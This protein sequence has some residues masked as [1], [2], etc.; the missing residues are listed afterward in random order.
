MR[1]SR[2]SASDLGGLRRSPTV[3]R[4]SDRLLLKTGTTEYRPALVGTEWDGG[5]CAAFGANGAGFGACTRGAGGSLGLALL[6]VLGVI[7]KLFG[8][9]EPLFVGGE[10]E[11]LPADDALQD[12]I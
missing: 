9:E 10:D 3:P 2:D 5:L 1:L 4:R 12:P 11:V 7:D 6:A 8:V